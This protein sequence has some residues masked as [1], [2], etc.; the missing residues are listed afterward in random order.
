MKK[1]FW[2]KVWTA[3]GVAAVL[4]G[5]LGLTGGTAWAASP[6]K[7]SRPLQD[8]AKTV[9]P[10]GDLALK[11]L[12]AGNNRFAAALHKK[13]SEQEKGNL[14]YS[15]V[16]IRTVLAMTSAGAKGKTAEEIK[17]TLAF[18]LPDEALFAA[19]QGFEKHLS[20]NGKSGI[21]LFMANALWGQQGHRFLQPF[22]ERNTTSFSGGI[23]QADFKRGAE[24]A[25]GTIN[26]WVEEKTKEKVRDLIPPGGVSPLTRLV[27]VNAVYFYGFWEARFDQSLTKKDVFHSPGGDVKTPMMTFQE[28]VK[29]RYLDTGAFQAVELPYR[30]RTASMV[31]ILPKKA[32]GLAAI[33]KEAAG[34]KLGTW[35]EEISKT[36]AREVIVFL[37]KFTMTWGTRDI[38]GVLSALGIREAFEAKK[39]D[40]SGMDGAKPPSDEAF[41]IGAVFHKAFVDVNEEGT[42]AAAASAVVA[43]P[44]GLAEPPELPVFRADHPFL[45]VIRDNATGAILFMGRLV[46]PNS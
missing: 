10:A 9:T 41:F 37:P 19:F 2:K 3:A 23:F 1:P 27:L 38:K 29:A 20:A 6:K 17:K 31:A 39:A 44:G 33:E 24:E 4:A 18:D 25:R 22:I 35:L 7:D 13:L 36:G 32:G 40:F 16:S 5:V 26:T 43:G 14:F 12:A 34:G 30:G 15:P 45:F 46:H 11:A 42:E 8:E 21:E 28:A